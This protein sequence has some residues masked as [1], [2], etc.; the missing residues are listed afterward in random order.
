MTNKIL[1]IWRQQN[2]KL[3][4]GVEDNEVLR[5]SKEI[6]VEMLKCMVDDILNILLDLFYK[7]YKT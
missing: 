6:P 2:R 4:I 1:V 5:I 3:E 7:V